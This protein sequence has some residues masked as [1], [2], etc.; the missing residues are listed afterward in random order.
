MFKPFKM[1]PQ[2]GGNEI[3]LLLDGTPQK[4]ALLRIADLKEPIKDDGND[5][6]HD[7]EQDDLY[8]QRAI[9]RA[10]PTPN[11]KPHGFRSTDSRNLDNSL[12]GRIRN[13][14]HGTSAECV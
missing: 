7:G 11:I 14:L 1:W 6:K 12:Y 13:P 9:K 5:E 2:N 10:Y 4:F 8:R 3:G